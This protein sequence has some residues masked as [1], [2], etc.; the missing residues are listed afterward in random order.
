MKSV[1][2]SNTD[3]LSE[4]HCEHRLTAEGW[5]TVSGKSGLE[6]FYRPSIDLKL[7]TAAVFYKKGNYNILTAT[8][9]AFRNIL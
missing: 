3:F 7:L 8:F 2:S 1:G 5:I 9:Q 4:K 6:Y